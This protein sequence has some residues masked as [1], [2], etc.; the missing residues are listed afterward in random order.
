VHCSMR[1]SKVDIVEGDEDSVAREVYIYLLGPLGTVSSCA[2]SS[3]FP[4]QFPLLG[5]SVRRNYHKEAL[6]WPCAP[7]ARGSI[8]EKIKQMGIEA[9]WQHAPNK[10]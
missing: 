1:C 8:V 6:K 5:R 3:S 10:R 7:I 9:S 2:S 4:H